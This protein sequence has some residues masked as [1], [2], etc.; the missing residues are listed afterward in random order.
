ML[1]SQISASNS[2]HQD[3]DSTRRGMYRL[4]EPPAASSTKPA[5]ETVAIPNHLTTLS[6]EPEASSSGTSHSE[7]EPTAQLHSAQ[8]TPTPTTPSD[9]P[10]SQPT[11]P[12]APEESATQPPIPRTISMSD[13]EMD[14]VAAVL[15]MRRPVSHVDPSQVVL[16]PSMS[17][18]EFSQ[19]LTAV[20]DVQPDACVI[21]TPL[22]TTNAADVT[23][24]ATQ[25][26]PWY[27]ARNLATV[28]SGGPSR[29]G[30]IDGVPE[31]VIDLPEVDSTGNDTSEITVDLSDY[32]SLFDG[33]DNETHVSSSQKSSD[34]CRNLLLSLPP[35]SSQPRAPNSPTHAQLNIDEDDLPTWMLKKKQWKYIA[36]TPGGPAWENLLKVYMQQERRLE[37]TEMVSNLPAF[38]MS[39]PK[40]FTGRDSH[41]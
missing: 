26:Q 40:P 5:S 16:V 9:Q 20:M 2:P 31:M 14:A 28:A 8:D 3:K 13:A 19:S 7:A 6:P 39:S 33:S 24:V 18:A 22:L 38:S 36:S 15:G 11:T 29:R 25:P 23:M 10:V 21:P 34:E 27:R 30:S 1:A 4:P 32:I 17:L 35:P 41:K 37:F 12:G